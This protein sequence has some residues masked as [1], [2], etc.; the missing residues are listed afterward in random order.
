MK[1]LPE[2]VRAYIEALE[3]YL[4]HLEHRLNR[5]SRNSSVPPSKDPTRESPKRKTRG[6][7]RPGGQEGHLGVTRDL[8]KPDRTEQRRPQICGRCGSAIPADSKLVGKP[9]ILQQREFVAKPTEVIQ[10]EYWEC[11][12]NNCGHR[13]RAEPLPG[14]EQCLGPRLQATATFL[15]G[16]C[17]V[18][19]AKTANFFMEVLGTPI[20]RATLCGIR[21][22]VAEALQVSTATVFH[23]VQMAPEKGVD[24]TGWKHAGQREYL[25]TISTPSAAFFGIFPSH[26]R[27]VAINL[28]GEE[29]TGL[30]MT[31]GYAVYN[32]IPEDQHGRCCAHLQRDFEDLAESPVPERAAF[33][34]RGLSILAALFLVVQKAKE[35]LLSALELWESLQPVRQR[36]GKLLWDGRLGNDEKLQGIATRLQEKWTSWFLFPERGLDATNNGAERALRPGVIWRGISMGTRSEEGVAYV[37]R[38]MT[39][40]ETAKRQGKPTMP[41]LVKLLQCH[42]AGITSPPISITTFPPREKTQGG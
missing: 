36:F 2:D 30:I 9:R 7:R 13:N 41:F 18:S 39:A 15:N 16:S 5:N 8:E 40:L 33:G 26:G 17:H 21:P 20:S 42:Q 1:E 12:C 10:R 3:Q 14:E 11:D 29:P 32:F 37:S 4:D 27:D 22:K 23:E 19:L 24:E 34:S 25:W 38:L 35:G 28:L 31:D 6:Q